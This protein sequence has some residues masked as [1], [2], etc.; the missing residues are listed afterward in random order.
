MIVVDRIEG[1]R[2]VLEV[3]GE[4]IDIP[5][6]AL[7]SGCGEGHALSLVLQDQA[8]ERAEAEDRLRR[9]AER[10]DLPDDIEL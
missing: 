10:H 6:T 2:A 1:T 8:A 4:L 3:D 5:V 9:L 7:P